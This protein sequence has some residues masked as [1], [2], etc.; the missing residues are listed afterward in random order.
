MSKFSNFKWVRPTKTFAILRIL[1]VKHGQFIIKRNAFGKIKP[2]TFEVV[3]VPI[4]ESKIKEIEKVL[5]REVNLREAK[6]EDL[7]EILKYMEAS[8]DMDYSEQISNIKKE[9]EYRARLRLLENDALK[10]ATITI[11]FKK[12]NLHVVSNDELDNVK[13]IFETKLL[14]LADDDPVKNDVQKALDLINAEKEFRDEKNSLDAAYPVVTIKYKEN[15][16]KKVEKKVKYSMKFNFLFTFR[17]FDRIMSLDFSGIKIDTPKIVMENITG[18][19]NLPEKVEIDCDYI[20]ELDN[21]EK[22]IE[23]LGQKDNEYGDDYLKY[24]NQFLG[25]QLDVIMQDTITQLI[26]NDQD[27]T[28]DSICESCM[29][30]LSDVCSE[31]GFKISDVVFK[32]IARPSLE[33]SQQ[34]T[35]MFMKKC[36][37]LGIDVDP[38]LIASI[39]DDNPSLSY[40]Q[41]AG[42]SG[43][44]MSKFVNGSRKNQNPEP[45]KEDIFNF[46]EEYIVLNASRLSSG[47]IN[48]FIN[49]IST[50]IKNNY[51]SLNTNPIIYIKQYINSKESELENA[52][53][54]GVEKYSSLSDAEIIEKVTNDLISEGKFVITRESVKQ[55][56]EDS[57]SIKRKQDKANAIEVNDFIAEFIALNGDE[58]FDVDIKTFMDSIE[59][60]LK[61]KFPNLKQALLSILKFRNSQIKEIEMFIKT[62]VEEY[63]SFDDKKIFDLV[64]D[65]LRNQ[66]KYL[67]TLNYIEKTIKNEIEI[68]RSKKISDNQTNPQAAAQTRNQPRNNQQQSAQT[69]DQT[70]QQDSAADNAPVNDQ[71]RNQQQS[72][73]TTAQTRQQ[74]SAADNA[75]VND[76]PSNQQQNQSNNAYDIDSFIVESM[77]ELK[78]IGQNPNDITLL[79]NK[80]V[81]LKKI[82]LEEAKAIIECKLID[83][84]I[85]EGIDL[86]VSIGGKPTSDAIINYVMNIPNSN[87]NKSVVL[88][89]VTK[90]LSII[91]SDIEIVIEV[92]EKFNL[93]DDSAQIVTGLVTRFGYNK[94]DAIAA[95][96]Q[97]FEQKEAAKNNTK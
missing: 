48:G 54:K 1:E 36:S 91:F 7:N 18:K 82:S 52:I 69:T 14:T 32:D 39:L 95:V 77:A 90:Q 64:V 55:Q 62:K 80:L 92:L 21:F 26:K 63:S 67:I 25:S 46:I 5:E 43:A 12:V 74:Q 86:L 22:F 40:M 37:E 38:A 16:F 68:M 31:F 72:A 94:D 13:Q 2:V 17:W 3:P 30:K 50:E 79:A 65:G 23:K 27:L 24:L 78:G 51:P 9:K 58:F 57:I 10:N 83:K 44:Q 11:K 49:S 75:P 42:L 33:Q 19:N 71:L 70:R 47:S 20:I 8:N 93:Q 87:F 66:N 60:G 56:I 76:Q 96:N 61:D 59:T 4:P 88:Q 89:R 81:N 29:S 53:K 34:K 6:D 35:A 41:I 15:I 73:Q 97:Y 85:K 45:T 28:H 84:Y